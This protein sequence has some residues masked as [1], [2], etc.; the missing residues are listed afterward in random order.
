MTLENVCFVLHC[1]PGMDMFV[2]SQLAPQAPKQEGPLG[3]CS[4]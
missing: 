1:A 3:P 2:T 4:S